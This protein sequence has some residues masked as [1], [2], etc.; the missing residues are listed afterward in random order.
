MTELTDHKRISLTASISPS[1]L[2]FLR[3][4]KKR[5][6]NGTPQVVF[7]RIR[8]LVDAIDGGIKQIEKNT[9]INFKDAPYRALIGT[10]VALLEDALWFTEEK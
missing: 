4:G 7:D 5:Q 10:V 2:E 8:P 3:T 1:A 9:G 6:D